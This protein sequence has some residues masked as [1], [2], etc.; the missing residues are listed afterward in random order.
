MCYQKDNINS[1]V[2]FANLAERLGI[3]EIE[4]D[5]LIPIASKK[6]MLSKK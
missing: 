6:I 2:N 3:D 1:L 5:S 4:Y